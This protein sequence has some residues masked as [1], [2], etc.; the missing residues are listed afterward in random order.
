[1]RTEWVAVPVPAATVVAA[2]CRD[3]DDLALACASARPVLACW[4][5]ANPNRVNPATSMAVQIAA[6]W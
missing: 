5:S 3:A 4:T 2:W 1:V 6:N